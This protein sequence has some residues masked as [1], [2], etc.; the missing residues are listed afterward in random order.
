MR[1]EKSRKRDKEERA[2]ATSSYLS[3]AQRPEISISHL[4][5]LHNLPESLPMVDTQTNSEQF[6]ETFYQEL[7]AHGPSG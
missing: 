1:G 7:K 4:L 2:A 5:D 6:L 3:G